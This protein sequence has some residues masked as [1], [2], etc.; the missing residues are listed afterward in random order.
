MTGQ[1]RVRFK[2]SPFRLA[3]HDFKK[4][5]RRPPPGLSDFEFFKIMTDRRIEKEK[6]FGQKFSWSVLLFV[7]LSIS[8]IDTTIT[9]KTA[10][11]DL[12]IPKVYIVFLLSFLTAYS[13]LDMIGAGLAQGFQT[14]AAQRLG[15]RFPNVNA[16][17]ATQTSTS[18]WSHVFIKRFESFVVPN[19]FNLGTLV[20]LSLI[21]LPVGLVYAAIYISQIVH[22]IAFYVRPTT[23][24]MG[25]L[26]NV[27]SI[28]LLISPI[29][30]V[31]FSMHKVPLRKNNLH[32][33]WGFLNRIYRQDGRSD[34]P[35]HWFDRREPKE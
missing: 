17:M 24:L 16:W 32:V 13:I 23:A 28:I 21:L 5:F 1:D 10:L 19:T 2:A 9:I 33:R 25:G 3:V 12:E 20:A 6:Q 35:E 8:G 11:L 15:G 22:I 29:F 4:T 30:L 31:W 14:V 27:I 34:Y 26:V 18:V 7:I